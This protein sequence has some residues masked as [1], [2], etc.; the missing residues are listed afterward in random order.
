MDRLIL[1]GLKRYYGTHESYP[2]MLD[3]F[4]ESSIRTMKGQVMDCHFRDNHGNLLLEN[5]TSA[6]YHDIAVFKTAFYSFHLPI[7]LGLLFSGIKDPSIHTATEEASRGLGLFFQM[8][9]DYIDLFGSKKSGKGIDND[10]R[11][12][13]VTW[14]AAQ[15]IERANL[16]QRNVFK[17]NYG[18]MDADCVSRIRHLYEEMKLFYLYKDA[19]AKLY[20]D[21]VKSYERYPSG[22]PTEFLRS[23]LDALHNRSF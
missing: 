19:Q 8:Q 12:G 2:E 17:A 10:I 23:L 6:R 7:A 11:E 20:E 15:A 4:Y 21:A 14:F 16:D 9:D 13:K 5:F 3:L 22:T 18:Q 1:A